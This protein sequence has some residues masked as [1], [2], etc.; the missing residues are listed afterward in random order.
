VLGIGSLSPVHYV[1]V[2]EYLHH[3]RVCEQIHIAHRH[4][5]ENRA[6]RSTVGSHDSITTGLEP[7]PVLSLQKKSSFMSRTHHRAGALVC[8]HGWQRQVERTVITAAAAGGRKKP[9]VRTASLS[10][11]KA[12]NK[13]QKVW[14]GSIAGAC[15]DLPRLSTTAC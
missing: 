13:L 11:S 10:C 7:C 5:Q 6:T 8:M 1:Q 4:R 12:D 14:K 9:K 15:C 3:T 2:S